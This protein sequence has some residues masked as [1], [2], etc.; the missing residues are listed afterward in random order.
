MCKTDLITLHYN[1]LVVSNK[2]SVLLWAFSLKR[3]YLKKHKIV[4]TGE[5]FYSRMENFKSWIADKRWLESGRIDV[6]AEGSIRD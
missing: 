2:N 1:D 5:Q 6:I 3:W 4:L